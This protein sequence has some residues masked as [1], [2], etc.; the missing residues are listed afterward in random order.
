[1]SQTSTDRA[2]VSVLGLGAMGSALAEA[3]LAAGHPTTVWNRSPA[4][5]DP[6][7]AM[8]A[9]RAATAA[10]AISVNRLVVVCLLD[11]RSVHEV[12]DD[13]A[14]KLAGKTLVNLTNGTPG[15]AEEF[16]RWAAEHGADYLDGGIMA[17]PPM[18][19][20]PDAFL[21]YSGSSG[22]FDEYRETLDALGESV[23]L[24]TEPGQAA[25]H[26]L[27]LLSGMY[28]MIAGILHSFALI[29]ADRAETFAP[30]LRRWLTTMTAYVDGAAAQITEGDYTLGVVSN[31]AMQAEGYV[32]ILRV[33]E[34]ENVTPVLLAPLGPLMQRRVAD[35]YGHE[36]ITGL[37]ELLTNQK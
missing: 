13:V 11:Y 9:V 16:A 31:L 29:G 1:M 15:Q 4:K 6:L 28:G 30:L 34:E 33:A 18:I 7:V 12:L 2:A 5:A 27:S 35:G 10:E 37:V 24:G 26:D 32:N 36:D 20:T 17:V 23:F 3:L 25:L 19:A 21:L 22:A 8:G 14:G